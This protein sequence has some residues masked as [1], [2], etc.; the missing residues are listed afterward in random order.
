[1]AAK[2]K[3]DDLLFLPLGGAGEIGMNV[4]LY[5]YKGKWIMF[6]LGAGF[7]D[8]TMPGVDMMAPDLEFVYKHKKD[9]LGV[10]LTHAHEDH[11]G[12]VTYLWGQLQCPLYTTKF[13][14]SVIKA[15][16]EGDGIPYAGKI[17]IVEPNSTFDVGPFNIELVQI[18]H[19]IPEMN[20]A[21]INTEYGRIMHTGDWKIDPD[22]VI[23][24][25]TDEKRLRGYGDEGVLCMVCDS[26]NVLNEGHSGSEGDLLDS[27]TEI[28]GEQKK[29]VAVTTF[30]SNVARIDTIA[31]A[32]EKNG[33]KV[34]LLGR[35]L[36]RIVAAAK[37]NGYLQDIQFINERQISR[38]RKDEVLCIC[39]GCQGEPMAAT[40]KL[41]HG[42]HP[43][44]R[45]TPGDTVIFS[46]KVIPGNEKKIYRM[47]NKLL[48]MGI[49]VVTE[50]DHFVHVSGHPCRE[51]LK[52]MY[53]MLRPEIAIPVHGEALHIHEHIKLARSLGVPKQVEVANGTMVRIA[54]GEPERL[55]EEHFGYL[56]VDGFLLTPID[57]EVM[58]MRRK[59]MLEGIVFVSLMLNKKG[60]S[61]R[62][63]AIF[64]PGVLDERENAGFIGA[65]ADE[66]EGNLHRAGGK[67]DDKIANTVQKTVRNFLK[68]EIGKYPKVIVNV[69]RV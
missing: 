18:T 21:I 59:M 40:S 52:H 30:A 60:K 32:A 43:V 46:S 57:G 17:N 44:I 45:L 31:R 14:A 47:H 64:T 55:G 10:V 23:G 50:K 3:K 54:P 8:D 9:F 67:S 12:A 6:D 7:A 36:G 28:I 13:T 15:K 19:S 42:T 5:H 25:T 2:Y 38:M 34:A 29:F 63:P 69:A 22:P 58:K 16:L 51:E 41:V 68:R 33:R 1:M 48:H 53:E 37:E 66:V 4:N 49:E 35:S 11:I 61:V 56:G 20:G 27:L 24:E 26:T 65:I 62:R 39:T